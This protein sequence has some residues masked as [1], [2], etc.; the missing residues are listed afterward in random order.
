VFGAVFGSA[1]AELRRA[2]A[3]LAECYGEGKLGHL[4]D[5]VR[6]TA[7]VFRGYLKSVE[8]QAVSA[9]DRGTS[10]VF[11]D[12]IEVLRNKDV[13]GAFGLPPAPGGSWPVDTVSAADTAST[14][15]AYLIEEIQRSLV[16]SAA[17]TQQQF[18]L[19]QRVAHYGGLT[20]A[21]VLEDTANWES[22][23]W[24]RTLVRDAFGWESALQSP[25]FL[26]DINVLPRVVSQQPLDEQEL[27]S[28]PSEGNARQS[29]NQIIALIGGGGGLTG[30]TCSHGWTRICDNP[31]HM[32]STQTTSCT[33]GS[34]FYCDTGPTC[35]SGWTLR[36]DLWPVGGIRAF[37]SPGLGG[38]TAYRQ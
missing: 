9:A 14:D 31:T 12:A 27:K 13:A 6:E 21:G 2:A 34:T 28:L 11:R 19:L 35:T 10:T 25:V 4:E 36:C 32:A 22:A 7:A 1:G 33:Y 26:N 3:T 29:G 24:I 15:A 37:T 23:D 16:L 5:R 20:I 8:G 38:I 30:C 17:V 18:I